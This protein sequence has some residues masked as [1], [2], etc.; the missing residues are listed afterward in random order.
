MLVIRYNRTGRRNKPLFRLVVQEK[1]VAP[2]GR[3]IE[4]VGNW[5]PHK[6]E[7]GFKKDRIEYWMGKGAQASDSVHN[8]LIFQ[9][10]ITGE[11]RVVRMEHPKKEEV[12]PAEEVVTSEEKAP[13]EEVKI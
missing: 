11:K 4:V 9:G 8:L 7:G 13:S 3:H 10:I 12:I 2:G 5:N 6:K 1:A